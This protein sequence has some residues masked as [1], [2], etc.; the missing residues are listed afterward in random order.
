MQNDTQ[1]DV[2]R[3]SK[4]A[5]TENIELY[6]ESIYL[7]DSTGENFIENIIHAANLPKLIGKLYPESLGEPIL[8][9]GFGEGTIT[10]PLINAGCTVEIVEGSSKLCED[11]TAKFGASVKV[12]CELFENFDPPEKFQTV[13]SLHVLEHIDSPRDVINRIFEWLKPGGQV[14]AVVPNA[15]SF[16]RQLAVMMGLQPE[17]NSLSPR[18]KIVGHQRVLTLDELSHLFEDARFNITEKFGYF[19]KTVPNSMMVGYP[20]DLI[21]ALTDISHELPPNLMANIGLVATKT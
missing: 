14:I 11:A 12:H 8:E 7:E 4:N 5:V 15:E 19:L 6:A 18:D 21:K 1:R 10:A 13:L 9:M 3:A 17:L 16:H 20:P 2:S